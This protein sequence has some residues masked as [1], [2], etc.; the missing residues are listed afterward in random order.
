M[1]V[2]S[3]IAQS[4]IQYSSALQAINS[5]NLAFNMIITSLTAGQAITEHALA[6]IDFQQS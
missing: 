2:D 6:I 3:Q 1:F 4:R 5:S